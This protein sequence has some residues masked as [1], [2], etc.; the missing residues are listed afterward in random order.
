MYSFFLCKMGGVIVL[1]FPTLQGEKKK[2]KKNYRG[3]QKRKMITGE[4]IDTTKGEERM[5]Q[6]SSGN[7]EK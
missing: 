3:R 6:N 2:V 1:F 7:E 5:V 4:S